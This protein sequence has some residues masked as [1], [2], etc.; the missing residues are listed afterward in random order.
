NFNAT[1][2]F[3]E[4]VF[5]GYG[6]VDS[7]RDDYGNVDV[8]GKLVMLIAGGPNSR[9]VNAFQ[10]QTYALQ[11][12]AAAVLIIQGNVAG[13]RPGA[14]GQMSL[15]SGYARR[16]MPNIFNISEK[17]AQTILGAS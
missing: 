13:S 8:K 10:K 7:T 16:I 12:G 4:L 11:K 17:V 14:K 2:L 6:I 5:A 9:N 15:G 1:Q 3:S